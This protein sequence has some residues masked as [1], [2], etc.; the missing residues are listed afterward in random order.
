MGG[1]SLLIGYARLQHPRAHTER[2]VVRLLREPLCTDRVVGGG[3]N[4][5]VQ[6]ANVYTF[7]LT[8]SPQI[9]CEQQCLR[10]NFLLG[11]LPVKVKLSGCSI[12]TVCDAF[13]L[14]L[15]SFCIRTGAIQ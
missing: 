9:S 13:V 10:K 7:C 4:V 14:A 15:Y 12:E 8:T 2:R 11:L 3:L 6:P 1:A 5:F